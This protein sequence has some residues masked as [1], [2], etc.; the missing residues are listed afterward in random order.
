MVLPDLEHRYVEALDGHPIHKWSQERMLRQV[1]NKLDTKEIGKLYRQ[2]LTALTDDKTIHALL[3]LT[4]FYRYIKN[5]DWAFFYSIFDNDLDFITINEW[6]LKL[7]SISTRYQVSIQ[8]VRTL[9]EHKRI[10]NGNSQVWNDYLDDYHLNHL[11]YADSMRNRLPQNQLLR[12]SNLVRN[13]QVNDFV[14]CLH[15][16]GFT[17]FPAVIQRIHYQTPTSDLTYDVRY[18][19]TMDEFNESLIQSTAR[20]FLPPVVSE[21]ALGSSQISSEG[22]GSVSNHFHQNNISAKNNHHHNNNNNDNACLNVPYHLTII[23]NMND[24]VKIMQYI[25]SHVILSS[26]KSNSNDND[27][28]SCGDLILILQMESFKPIMHCSAYINNIL[29]GIHSNLLIK[30]L[31]DM[32]TNVFAEDEGVTCHHFIEFCL[33]SFDL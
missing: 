1:F 19:L 4:L 13:L 29:Y 12:K 7:K 23:R 21:T 18:I 20:K 16:G 8:H 17:W 31:Q 11:S 25:F 15:D 5:R 27:S 32:E 24:E 33:T 9:D 28:V 10:V 6:L 22:E 2:S 26:V 3:K 14:W 30:L